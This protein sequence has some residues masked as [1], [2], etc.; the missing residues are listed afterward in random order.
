MNKIS[1]TKKLLVVFLA[2]LIAFTYMPLGIGAGK[3]DATSGITGTFKDTRVLESATGKTFKYSS[4]EMQWMQVYFVSYAG[5]NG[6]FKIGPVREVSPIRAYRVNGDVAYCLEHGV[7]ADET[8]T[9]TGKG[10]EESFL[11]GVY[12]SAKLKYIIDNMSLCLLYGRQSRP[13]H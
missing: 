11:E 4:D 3:A 10:K 7:M 12:D 5:R 8:V 6:G 13:L 1:K 2:F 9:L